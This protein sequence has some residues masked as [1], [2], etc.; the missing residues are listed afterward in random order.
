MLNVKPSKN[1]FD[2]IGNVAMELIQDS[3]KRNLKEPIEVVNLVEAFAA[4]KHVHEEFLQAAG[5]YLRER[6]KVGNPY[7]NL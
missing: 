5:E 1:V 4:L 6:V 3:L 2:T 7:K